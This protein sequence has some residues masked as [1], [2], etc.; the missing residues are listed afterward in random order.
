[1]H[2]TIGRRR[3][4]SCVG[5]HVASGAAM[6]SAASSSS[7]PPAT[8][9]VK[10]KRKTK[11]KFANPPQ[12]LCLEPSGKVTIREVGWTTSCMKSGTLTLAEARLF[13]V[14]KLDSGPNPVTKILESGPGPSWIHTTRPYCY[15]F[16]HKAP[17]APRACWCCMTSDASSA[18]LLDDSEVWPHLSLKTW[19]VGPLKAADLRLEPGVQCRALAALPPPPAFVHIDDGGEEIAD[20]NRGFVGAYALATEIKHSVRAVASVKGGAVKLTL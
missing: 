2:V 7:E 10:A 8:Q 1:M 16:R 3:A 17:D 18:M 5:V 12:Y 14:Y 4:K 15:L 13:G 19:Q 11:A 20:S 9:L 6:S